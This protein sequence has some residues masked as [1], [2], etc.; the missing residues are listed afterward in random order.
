MN[1]SQKFED[2][3]AGESGVY[4]G[5][6][7]NGRKNKMG[8]CCLCLLIASGYMVTYFHDILFR[9]V[10]TVL[11][12]SD[13]GMLVSWGI[14]VISSAV[15]IVCAYFFM[16]GICPKMLKVLTGGR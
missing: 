2:Y 9:I 6:C 15:F 1:L 14:L 4:S 10:R 12:Y 3:I 5:K 16:D 13:F 11:N 8:V 7:I